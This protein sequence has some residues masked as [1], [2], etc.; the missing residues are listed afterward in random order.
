MEQLIRKEEALN[1]LFEKWQPA[2]Q[3][4]I[5]P[6]A[7]AGGRVLAQD[8]LAQ[9]N[10]PVVRASRMDGIA[11]RSKD[12]AEGKP[13]TS[14]WREGVD[15]VRADTG[16]DFDDAYDAVIAIEQVTFLP[17][18][19]LNLS[20]D[21]QVSAGSFV[22]PCGADL[23]EGTL[24]AKAGTVLQAQT[25]AAIA[26][27]GKA[28]VA[29]VQK[30]RV[31]FIPT[32][33]E[34]VAAGAELKRG[35]NFDSNSILA[36]QMLRDMGA[37]PVMHPIVPDDPGA[38]RT[39]LRSVWEKSDIVIINAGTSKG[40]EDYSFRML[41]EAGEM[42]FHGVAAVPGRPMSMAVAEGKPL[43]NLS[44]PAFAAFYSVDW[45]VR[46]IICRALGIS[47]PV[48]ERVTAVLAEDLKTPP[49]MSMMLSLRLTKRED[50]T[51]L[52]EPLALRGKKAAGMAASLTADAVYISTPGEQPLPAGS[53]IE[54][55]LLK[56]RSEIM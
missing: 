14:H 49:M 33:S 53:P 56:N 4:E 30:P 29:V 35:Q 12:F 11:V 6:L 15:Y 41:E 17:E 42:L 39:A 28:E 45:A 26:M 37:E 7:Q 8:I 36:A 31:A 51:Y 20:D 55:E 52:A 3:T 2:L 9:Y 38:I 34:L 40:G 24:I 54:V 23:K 43:I 13:D 10:L 1:R 46:A 27:A 50:G 18:G 19:G 25:M 48:R 16:D 32:G 47:I 21:V 22:K 5:I 44:G